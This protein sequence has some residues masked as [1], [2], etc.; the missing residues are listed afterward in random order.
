MNWNQLNTIDQLKTIDDLSNTKPVL[1][2]KHSTTCSIS[3][4]AL[5]R[6]ERNWKEE[7]RI[8]V[9]PYYL[10]L[11]SHRNVSNEIASHY[12]VQHQSPQ[13]LL[14]KEGKCVY[15]ETHMGINLAEIMSHLVG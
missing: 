2:L 8:F 13:V 11:L 6:L 10:D 1:I 9:E 15:S 7:D 3:A 4:T 12:N 5:N 14:I